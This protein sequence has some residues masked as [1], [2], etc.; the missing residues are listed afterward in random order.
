MHFDIPALPIATLV[1]NAFASVTLVTNWIVK[2]ERATDSTD[3][4]LG[5]IDWKV[6][7]GGLKAARDIIVV[8][9]SAS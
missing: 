6:S 4:A 2:E 8:A 9:S 1:M 3:A 7:R 5:K